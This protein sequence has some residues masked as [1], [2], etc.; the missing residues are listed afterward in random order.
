MPR[1]SRRRHDDLDGIGSI[2]GK[3]VMVTALKPMN[4]WRMIP[5]RKLERNVFKLQKRIFRA[6]QRGATATVHRLQKLLMKSWSARCLAVRRVTQDNRGKKTAGIDGIKSL[7]PNQ[8]LTLADNLTLSTKAQPTRRVWIPKPGGTEKRGLAIPTMT[9]RARQALVKLALEPEWEARFEP[10][11][12]GFRPGRSGH[13]AIE[14]I[15]T[16]IK[17]KAKYVLD[18][19]IAKC[20]DQINQTALLQKLQT[21]PTIRRQIK[22]WLK[23]GVMEGQQ[24]F[25]TESGT[26][27]GG[28]ISPLLAN[29]ALHGM[30]EM[31]KQQYPN[32]SHR[33]GVLNV[34]R[35]ADDFVV[36]HQDLNVIQHCQ[37][38][39]EQWLKRI[40]LELK[41]SKTQ[42]IHTLEPYMG[43]VGFSFLGFEVRQI[44]TG[45]HHASRGSHQRSLGFKTLI[46]PSPEK[47]VEHLKRTGDLIREHR[48]V[49]Q[50]TII[51]TLNPI[52][53]GWSN[54]YSTCVSK[55]IFAKADHLLYKQLKSW[56][57]HRH[58][59]KLGSW[60]AN[61][62]WHR[63]EEER[64]NFAVKQ[65]G[66]EIRLKL[67]RETSI[68]R[69]TK[70]KD[71]RS[72]FDGDWLYWS[73]RLGKH[74]EVAPRI[75][76]L[77][78][79]QKGKCTYCGLFFK[80]DDVMEVDHIHPIAK[81]G[82]GKAKNLQLLHRHCHDE[83]SRHDGSSRHDKSQV[84]EEPCAGK[85]AS[86]VL[87]PSGRGDSGA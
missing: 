39:I 28:V 42:I 11:S 48:A 23:A 17:Q 22:A 73:T 25:P 16:A 63:D 4:E 52:I 77:L 50:A 45:R 76:Q 46:R 70:V 71:R 27:Q 41:P 34:V 26:P 55:A 18:A 80:H 81:G 82:T 20:F 85:L 21:T 14:A 60:I 61:H 15:F 49:D 66:I 30:E 43:K 78:K 19:D 56:A 74:P 59:N 1:I 68:R 3:N 40:G 84:I 53:V 65:Q 33:K 37:E 67:H 58:H 86:T 7:T 69:H 87:K 57:K 75:A 51:R 38:L 6:T 36:I 35:Y 62:Y 5:W 13:D 2:S 44:K 83:K 79:Q 24:L 32:Q 9:E 12:F 10:G 64:W 8:R 31:L 54:Y 47:L 72:P 29:I